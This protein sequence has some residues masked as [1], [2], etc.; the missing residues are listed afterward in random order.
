M[1][2]SLRT[3]NGRMSRSEARVGRLSRQAVLQSGL[4]AKRFTAHALTTLDVS[5]ETL[6][7]APRS[8]C[9]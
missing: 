8:T 3:V 4:S 2:L 7:S 5:H 1:A 6:V 9:G